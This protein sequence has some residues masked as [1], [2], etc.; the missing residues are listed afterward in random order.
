M[1]LLKSWQLQSSSAAVSLEATFPFNETNAIAF[2]H[3]ALGQCRR[4]RRI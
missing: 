4:T 3:Q 1:L 2:A